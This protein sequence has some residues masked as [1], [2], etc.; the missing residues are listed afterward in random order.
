MKR[1]ETEGTRSSKSLHV[2]KMTRLYV[3]I[4]LLYV[5]FAY[6]VIASSHC[7][8]SLVLVSES[9]GTIEE[10]LIG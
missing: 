2:S 7:K 10:L 9:V 1:G 3:D 6:Y 5:A 8:S 4:C